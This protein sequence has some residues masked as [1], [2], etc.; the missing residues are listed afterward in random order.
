MQNHRNRVIHVQNPLELR[1]HFVYVWVWKKRRLWLAENL[2]RPIKLVLTKSPFRR[3]RIH[4]DDSDFRFG[5]VPAHSVVMELSMLFTYLAI[6]A[7]IALLVVSLVQRVD[8][9]RLSYTQRF[10]CSEPS[11]Y[12][13]IESF[14]RWLSD[15]D[16]WSFRWQGDATRDMVD[17]SDARCSLELLSMCNCYLSIKSI[18]TFVELN[19]SHVLI[20]RERCQPQTVVQPKTLKGNQSQ[21]YLMGGETITTTRC[22][23]ACSQVLPVKS[24]AGG[25]GQKCWSVSRVTCLPNL[26]RVSEVGVFRALQPND[27]RHQYCGAKSDLGLH[28]SSQVPQVAEG[29]FTIGAMLRRD[30]CRKWVTKKSTARVVYV[31]QT[32]CG[33]II[34]LNGQSQEEHARDPVKMW[35]NYCKFMYTLDDILDEGSK[36]QNGMFQH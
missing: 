25:L 7:V 6:V 20:H 3:M 8:T 31:Y 15:P 22:A 11:I 33:A 9:C 12:W 13:Q 2:R 21:G 26:D 1:R 10:A 34:S 27:T 17:V 5:P 4:H 29:V 19:I 32:R 18:C 36:F 23:P 14:Y 16:E 30:W 28:N 35:T 24:H